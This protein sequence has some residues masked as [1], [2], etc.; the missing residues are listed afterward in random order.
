MKA[1]ICFLI[2]WMTL[3][4]VL[5]SQQYK[6]NYNWTVGSDPVVKF[7][8]SNGI[9]IDTV[10]NTGINNPPFCIL[11]T[12]SASISDT[13]GILQFFTNGYVIY[14]SGGF[15]MQN[16]LYV[17]CPYGQVLADYY[18]GK[19][20]FEQ[21]SIILP[22]KGNTYYVFSTGMSDSVANNYV[23]HTYTEFD[24]LNYSVVDMDSNAGKGKVVQKNI[25][26]ADKQHYHW[27]PLSAIKHHN[28]KDWWLVKADCSNNRF[29][30]FLVKEDT[31]MGPY[32]QNIT[33]TGDFCT[34]VSQLYF[35]E[36][37]AQMA[38]SQ[39]G[40]IYAIGGNNFYYYNR[41]E[42]Y[43]FDRCDGTI[44]YK[45]N[46]I[47]PYDTSSYTNDDFKR[48][49]CFSPNGKLLYM[50]TN[51]SVFQIDLEDT[52][53]S[54]ALYIH[55][56]DTSNLSYFP[57]YGMMGIAPDGKIYIGNHNGIRSS[58]SYIDSPNVK[59]LGCNFMSQGVIQPFNNNLRNPP[60]MPNYGLGP[61]VGVVC[62]PL[63]S[64]HVTEIDKT[65]EV[66]PNPANTVIYIKTENAGKKE[67]YNSVGQLLLS[68]YM[69]EINV[70][71][72]S[73]GIYYIKVGNEVQKIIIE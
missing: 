44:T 11:S 34:A 47:V 68:T 52:N 42:I 25:V 45:K 22:K 9:V 15:V 46:Y 70:S 73:E 61:D 7:N 38:C 41:V 50:S 54:N 24:V 63:S 59:G 51:Y 28:G 1:K 39:Y 36:D 32:Y 71:R 66:Y 49:I 43:D 12:E 62:W 16:G 18:G 56:P 21:T 72:Y 60:N 19:S 30:E 20:L 57:L 55:G 53:T 37:G 27:T 6:R 5:Y 17:N 8:F 13:S 4:S 23:N 10:D 48:G 58:M 26:L 33:T 40:N 31:I 2:F 14:D 65:F 69:N 29:Q 64:T 3:S 35:S 67:L